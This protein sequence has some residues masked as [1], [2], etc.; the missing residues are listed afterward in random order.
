[1]VQQDLKKQL[2]LHSLIEF[3][4]L[5]NSNLDEDFI[6]NYILLSIMGRMM[7][8]HGMILMADPGYGSDNFTVR[9]AKG[10]SNGIQ[11]T[12]LSLTLP[13]KP[14]FDLSDF[15]VQTDIFVKNGINNFFK[16]YYTDKL[17]G[18]LCL[19][20][21]SGKSEFDKSEIIY[22]ETLL[23]IS[24]ISIENSLK[25]EQINKLNR[26][27]TGE[28]TKLNSLFELSNIFYSNF[29]DKNK[30]IRLLNY[31]LLGN[32]GIRDILIITKYRANKYYILSQTKTYN[33]PEIDAKAV[34]SLRSNTFINE[35][36]DCNFF[37]FLSDEGLKLVIPIFRNDKEPE[38]V[39][40]LGNKLNG[41]SFSK[42]DID[43]LTSLVNLSVISIENS[44]LFREHLE[45][46]SM[47]NELKIARE[48]QQALLPT[49]IPQPE[50]YSISAVNKPAL[51]VGGDYFDIIRLNEKKYVIVIADVSGKGAPA[52]LLMSNI[53]SA[54]RSYIKV[55]NENIDIAL[56]TKKINELIF[57]NTTPEKFITF[58]WGILN[59]ADNTFRYVNAGHNYPMLFRKNGDIDF[60][61]TGGMIIG[62]ISEDIEYETGTVEFN[63][64]D[65]LIL[66]TDGINE[67][68]NNCNDEYEMERFRNC[69]SKVIRENT[70][71]IT[72]AILKDVN[73]FSDGETQSDDRTLIAI[74]RI[75]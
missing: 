31:T 49:I 7:I 44:I 70:N 50:N 12:V 42:S 10:I 58:F 40:F 29:E 5:I 71:A 43:F 45:K 68:K 30:I 59:T 14:V 28:L 39:V 16:I 74:K 34:Q 3:S 9:C 19:G 8:S 13:D 47:E 17:L 53:Q 46:L 54:V 1:M 65:V 20:N 73:E 22:I 4:N 21:K 62:V 33:I 75:N 35:K 56:V 6:L 38:T 15:K 57:E 60:L 41:T 51:H 52:A 55:F 48:I 63:P 24:S 64:D 61:E 72:S 2:E 67:A 32:Y 18:V 37:N 36:S 23:N 27:L 66:Y 25:F 11:G 26:E 69:V